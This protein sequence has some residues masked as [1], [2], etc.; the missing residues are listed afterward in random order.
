M[1]LK[2]NMKDIN[3]ILAKVHFKWNFFFKW[4]EETIHFLWKHVS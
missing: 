3:K 2:L 4:C 1:N